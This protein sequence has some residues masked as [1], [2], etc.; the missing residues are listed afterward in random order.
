MLAA[1]LA[2]LLRRWRSVPSILAAGTALLL[3]LVLVLMPRG[4]VLEIGGQEISLEEPVVVMG[5]ALVLDPSDRSAMGFLFISSALLFLLAW[6]FDRGGLF[7]PIGLGMLGLLSGALLIQPLI[8][9]ALLLQIAAV[10]AIFPL[11]AAEQVQV[12]VRGGLRY[13]TFYLLALPGLLVSHWLLE[14]FAF[15]PDEVGLLETATGLIGFSFALLLG[16]FPFH[17]WTPSLGSD[18]APLTSSFIYTTLTGGV[19][20]LLLDYLQV[21]PWLSEHLQ[22][23]ATL[24]LVGTATAVAGGVLGA[25]RRNPGTLMGY[26]VMFDTGLTVV[27]LAQATQRGLG[28]AIGLLFAR[29]IGTALMAAGL[30]GLQVRAG[31]QVDLPDGVG[32]QA[33]WSAMAFFIGGLSLVGFPPTIGFAARWALFSTVF[34]ANALVGFVLLI[35]SAGPVIGLMQLMVRLLR[36]P[37]R[38][39]G[40]PLGEPEEEDEPAVA[41]EPLANVILLLLVAAATLL[42][43]LFPQWV[44]SAA[45][46]L[47]DHFTFFR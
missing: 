47:A 8:Y 22:W 3:G 29:V 11:Y 39:P 27:A 20:F 46:N 34:Q 42:I 26:A 31:E 2:Y 19:W 44:M 12:Q 28:A 7:A 9:A 18:G 24:S 6:R 1:V 21:Y 45:Y 4:E 10:L 13:L 37:K 30:E 25:T 38:K 14:L 43:G 15:T 32:W 33:P 35:A 23:T 36:R 5:R 16:L 41:P 40:V 17:A